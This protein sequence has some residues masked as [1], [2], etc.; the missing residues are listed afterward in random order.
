MYNRQHNE[1]R[2]PLMKNIFLYVVLSTPISNGCSQ[3]SDSKIQAENAEAQAQAFSAYL[4]IDAKK[5]G[6]TY[7]ANMHATY[8][9]DKLEVKNLKIEA[10]K[11]IASPQF[12]AATQQDS[13]EYYLLGGSS[14]IPTY[15][16]KFSITTP[17]DKICENSGGVEITFG[18]EHEVEC[19]IKTVPASEATT[20]APPDQSENDEKFAEFKKLCENPFILNEKRCISSSDEFGQVEIEYGRIYEN[21]FLKIEN[22]KMFRELQTQCEKD[23]IFTLPIESGMERC[24]CSETLTVSLWKNANQFVQENKNPIDLCH[25]T[26]EAPVNTEEKKFFELNTELCKALKF[27]V[28]SID[29]NFDHCQCDQ[30]FFNIDEEGKIKLNLNKESFPASCIGAK[31]D[32]PKIEFCKNLKLQNGVN[33]C[34]CPSKQGQELEFSNTQEWEYAY[35]CLIEK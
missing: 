22:L 31:N 6:T 9:K 24:K 16:V 10:F 15:N 29:E 14:V 8:S 7:K 1:L 32:I 4:N 33:G 5:T 11:Q 28:L 18:K 17:D 26:P 34:L 23:E 21:E 27:T 12:V 20:P 13:E 19:T 30:E 35:E 3:Y 25:I 2:G